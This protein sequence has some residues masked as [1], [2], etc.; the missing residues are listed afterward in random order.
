[1]I[2]LEL[3]ILIRVK[4]IKTVDLRNSAR[5]EIHNLEFRIEATE[6]NREGNYS[7]LTYTEDKVWSLRG[8]NDSVI[9]IPLKI[10][11]PSKP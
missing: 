8:S 5:G 11:F 4:W 2:L 3:L 7:L 6:V 10:K 1:M 9:N